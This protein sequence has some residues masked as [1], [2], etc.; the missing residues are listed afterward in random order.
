[1]LIAST[2]RTFSARACAIASSVLDAARRDDLDGDDEA[3]ARQRVREPRF[4]LARHRRTLRLVRHP[5]GAL[6]A[7]R[8]PR[9]GRRPATRSDRPQTAP[10]S[11]PPP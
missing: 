6:G 1:M 8:R 3:A 9:A 7:A 4:V 5:A 2:P 11:G 10:G